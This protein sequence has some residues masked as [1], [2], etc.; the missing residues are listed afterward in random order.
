[1]STAPGWR[2][3]SRG[4]RLVASV[5]PRDTCRRRSSWTATLLLGTLFA[6]LM[7]G[8]GAVTERVETR[9]HHLS[10]RIAIDGD[11]AGGERF[12]EDLTIERL[13]LTPSTDAA[14]DVTDS[15]AAAGITLPANLDQ[16]LNAGE[17]V[18]IPLYYRARHD[19]SVTAY[20]TMVLRIGEIENG[21]LNRALPRTSRTVELRE[22]LV[23]SDPRVNRLQLARTLA[24]LAAMLCLG[25]VSSVSAVCGAGREE[26]TTE[27]LLVLPMSRRALAAGIA[28]GAYPV[29][30]A[31]LVAAVV[32]LIGVSA[33]PTAGL[34]QPWGS[35]ASMLAFGV[36]AALLLGLLAAA[37]GCLAGCLGT[38][39]D[40]TVGLGDFLALPFVL[41][42]VVLLLVP[43]LASTP[44]TYSL[45]AVG[46]A[47]A[48]RD[49]ISGSLPVWGG[50][51]AVVSTV[52]WSAGLVSVAAR[53]IGDERRI[54]RP[55]S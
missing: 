51:V 36:P 42:G 38:G 2:S 31:Q 21:L 18:E 40:D 35:V 22:Q 24:A 8:F 34:S 47:L 27:P 16:R 7:A 46:P 30:A 10:C 17:P 50:L 55:T 3:E 11:L 4:A 52:A 1:M 41:V 37:T 49:G 5:I 39:S 13:A 33:L 44:L 45:P 12:L 54:L 14:R 28:I 48:L 15:V 26:R 53:R 32:V 23:A 9:S 19:N 25:V 29:A 20:N 6:V 43:D